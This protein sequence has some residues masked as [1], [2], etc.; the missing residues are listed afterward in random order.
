MNFPIVVLTLVFISI[1][2]I[3]GAPFETI[4]KVE[5]EIERKLFSD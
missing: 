1:Q 4:K 5:I 2:K 3:L